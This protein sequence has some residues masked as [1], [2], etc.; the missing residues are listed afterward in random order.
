M[1]TNVNQN[2][3]TLYNFTKEKKIKRAFSALGSPVANHMPSFEGKI[4]AKEINVASSSEGIASF[5]QALSNSLADVSLN[6]NIAE[7]TITSYFCKIE[8]SN[9]TTATNFNDTLKQNIIAE[10]SSQLDNL[11]LLTLKKLG[12]AM[13]D[14]SPTNEAEI[15]DAILGMFVLNS[16]TFLLDEAKELYIPQALYS[17]LENKDTSPTSSESILDALKRKL[18]SS[19]TT[20]LVD[21]SSSDNGFYSLKLITS[22]YLKHFYGIEPCEYSSSTSDDKL[23]RFI[24]FGMS[25]GAKLPMGSEAEKTYAVINLNLSLPASFLVNANTVNDTSNSTAK[26]K[27]AKAK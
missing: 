11:D 23:K 27:V 14:V 15:I 25:V 12:F 24:V 22:D 3:Q 20:V 16:E 8:E 1:T 7:G 4:K 21:Y 18:K 13:A 17:A 2:P 9:T 26:E 19:N 10:M 5:R 6:Q